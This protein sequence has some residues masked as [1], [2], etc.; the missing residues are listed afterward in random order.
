MLQSHHIGEKLQLKRLRSLY[1][2]MPI[3]SYLQIYLPLLLAMTKIK[4]KSAKV[5]KNVKY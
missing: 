2:K 4:Q 3:S 5:Y 1:N